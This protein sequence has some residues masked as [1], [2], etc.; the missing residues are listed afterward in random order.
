M[1]GVLLRCVVREDPVVYCG[2]LLTGVELRAKAI[3]DCNG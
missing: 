2:R 3:S 1:T